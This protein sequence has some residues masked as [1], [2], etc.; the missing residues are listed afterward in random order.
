[1]ILF[2]DDIKESL[3]VNLCPE[4]RFQPILN[5][6]FFQNFPGEHAPDPL[7][8]VKNFFV[9]VAWVQKLYD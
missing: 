8:V 7:E 4:M 9:A 6:Y 1:M 2:D 5:T 3:K